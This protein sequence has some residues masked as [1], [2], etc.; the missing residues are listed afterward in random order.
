MEK[1]KKKPILTGLMSFILLVSSILVYQVF[2]VKTQQLDA[3]TIIEYANSNNQ[4]YYRNDDDRKHTGV[5]L[6]YYMSM[7]SQK[8]YAKFFGDEAIKDIPYLFQTFDRVGK[9]FVIEKQQVITFSPEQLVNNVA[10]YGNSFKTYEEKKEEKNIELDES[11]GINP[12]MELAYLYNLQNC[13]ELTDNHVIINEKSAEIL[14]VTIGDTFVLNDIE[15]KV[16][17]I[18]SPKEDISHYS[19]L[20]FYNQ[21]VN[22]P[23]I[24]YSDALMQTHFPPLDNTSDTLKEYDS[25]KEQNDEERL[26]RLYLDDNIEYRITFASRADADIFVSALMEY[27]YAPVDEYNNEA[28]M[29]DTLYQEMFAAF[30][31]NEA[32][33]MAEEIKQIDVSDD[34][35]DYLTPYLS[36][37]Q[38]SMREINEEL[39]DST[40]TTMPTED[41]QIC[42]SLDQIYITLKNTSDTSIHVQATDFILNINNQDYTPRNTTEF[43]ITLQPGEKKT[44]RFIYKFDYPGKHFGA[45]ATEE[46]K[47][48][49]RFDVIYYFIADGERIEYMIPIKGGNMRSCISTSK[50]K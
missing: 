24:M 46:E 35:F 30:E 22:M 32:K 26:A 19:A 45:D 31:A 8:L 47:N 38:H 33:F 13:A 39:P 43:P 17:A 1:F 12:Y 11:L 2:F 41:G 23:F 25:V 34:E 21:H 42:Y 20:D 18:L 49:Y 7:N 4:S 16:E 14:S 5:V 27:L 9:T 10:S 3:E 48:A 50:A 37:H 40:G 44:V 6:S 29:D 28:L 36:Y 15:L